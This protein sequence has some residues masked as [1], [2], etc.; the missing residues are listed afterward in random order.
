MEHPKRSLLKALTWRVIAFLVTIIA[1]YIY[2]KD[3]KQS[4][5]VGVGANS[6]KIFLYYAHERIWN[7]VQFGKIKGPEYQI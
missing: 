1:V 3:I 7:R 2:T 5:V 6:V 4:L